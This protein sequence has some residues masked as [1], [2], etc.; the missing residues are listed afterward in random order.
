MS[1]I[2]TVTVA[3]EMMNADA[4]REID[5]AVTARQGIARKYVR[6]LRRRNPE[7][8]PAEIIGMLERHYGVSIT[9]AGAVLAAGVIAA[10]I[11][12]AMIPVA[13]AAAAGAKSV[14]QQAA[15]QAV[16]Q[17]AKGA[18]KGAAKAMGL[19]AAK[20][21]AQHLAKL[22]PAGDQQ[23]QFEITAIF[24]LA[25]A[26]IHDMDLD[27]D[28]ARALVFGLSNGRVGP[29]QI[30]KMAAD[31]AESSSGDIV[32]VGRGI[33]A[34]RGDWS[35]W[36]NTLSGA[37]PAGA[38][39]EL[40]HVIETG[41]LDSVRESLN[42]KQRAGVEYGVGAVVGGVTRFVFGREVIEAS[43]TAFAAP[44]AE[45]P[46]H[47]QVPDQDDEDDEPNRAIAAMEE[48]AKTAGHWIA[49]VAGSVGTG[50]ATG[51]GAAGAGVASAASTV[52]RPFRS[53][54]L[55]GDGIRDEPQAVSAMKDAGGA[56]A[57]AAGAVG[58]NL[59]GMFRRKNRD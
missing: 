3:A 17:T 4:A 59:A 19:A 2:E 1:E 11:G 52:S 33:A 32:G 43:R 29:Q 56:I 45:F 50:V 54:D 15:K 23:L 44:P 27:H 25:L 12:I 28:Q 38:A 55:D 47:L 24:G 41:R 35:H 57:D 21:G 40:V 26:D 30:A 22:L 16:K 5:A 6:R 20:G 8:T 49:D 42:G 53:V 39:Q 31:L 34:G 48:A 36:A 58:E 14:G 7:A 37:L 13:G 51:A 9:T 10:D 18:A 46:V